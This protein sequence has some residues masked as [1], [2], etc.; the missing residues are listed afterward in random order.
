ME[1]GIYRMS[2]SG[3]TLREA[4]RFGG[5]PLK[6]IAALV[7]KFS[8]KKGGLQWF[9]PEESEQDCQ[10]EELSPEASAALAPLSSKMEALGYGGAIYSKVAMNLNP[11]VPQVF[12][13]MA[14]HKGSKRILHA[15]FT[16]ARGPA[17][18]KQAVSLS[19][20][21]ISSE[22]RQI[23]FVS[24]KNYLDDDGLSL[25]MRVEVPTL[26]ALDA[27]MA[28]YIAKEGPSLKS[29]PSSAEYKKTSMKLAAAAWDAR[30]ERGLFQRLSKEEE[31]AVL[32]KLKIRI[33]D[34]LRSSGKGS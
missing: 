29:F 25:R 27:A 2:F 11:N 13:I 31:N 28:D 6:F 33:P 12:G 8:G 7:L 3:L 21:M 10:E 15:A 1:P 30:I 24:H 20:G 22:M 23:S 4:W 16:L 26:E 9:P 17:G 14:L 19:G 34:G 5:G 18:M 32:L